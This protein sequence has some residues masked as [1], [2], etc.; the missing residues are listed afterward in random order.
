MRPAALRALGV[1]ALLGAAAFA[2]VVVWLG[3][4]EWSALRRL[5][6]AGLA[7]AL[8]ALAGSLLA[9]AL[10]LRLLAW[11]A[12]QALPWRQALRA[13]LLGMFA[14]TVT[15]GGSGGMPALSLVLRHGGFPVG[16][17]WATG[18]TVFVADAVFFTWATPASLWVLYRAGLLP[19]GPTLGLLAGGA[20]ALALAVAWL[21]TF[22]LGWTVPLAGALLR[23]PLR[24]WRPPATSF[25]RRLLSAQGHFTHAGAS[26]HVALQALTAAAWA[27]LF[28]VL[29]A[30]AHGLELGLSPLPVL[31]VLTVVTAVGMFVPTPGGSGV[32]EAGAA[33]LLV[34][35]GGHAGTA[36]AVLL[37]R[38]LTH[39]A[40]FLLGPPLGGYLLMRRME[41]P[42]EGQASSS[43]T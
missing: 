21:L 43:E 35:Q 19:P 33:L 24:R 11:Q 41:D 37:W 38:L 1:S 42:G 36:T 14:S 22:R 20:S 26:W 40:L 7:W 29:V 32:L 18:V 2:G 27:G 39:Y 5:R 15:P 12:R 13:H 30:V 6:P 10:R 25:L 9:A 3:T 4:D 16:T 28:L 31:A 17:A 23:G 34:A 8:V